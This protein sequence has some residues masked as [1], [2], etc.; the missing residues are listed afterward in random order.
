M[1]TERKKVYFEEDNFGEDNESEELSKT[2]PC[3]ICTSIKCS[4]IT[5][6]LLHL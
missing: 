6:I 3:V 1:H 4:F 2:V 5:E